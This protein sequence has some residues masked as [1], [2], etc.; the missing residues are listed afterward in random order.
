M[1]NRLLDELDSK[2]GL[3]YSVTTG[4][5]NEGWISVDVVGDGVTR[6]IGQILREAGVD[7][8]GKAGA[9]FEFYKLKD[10]S[11]FCVAFV[12]DVVKLSIVNMGRAF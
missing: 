3:T 10:D 9:G 12:G 11:T 5:S 7:G 1:I 6:V 2:E 4:G 8:Q